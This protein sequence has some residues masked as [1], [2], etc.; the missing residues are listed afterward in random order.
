MTSERVISALEHLI[1]HIVP[2]DPH[3]HPDAAQ[4]RHDARLELVTSMIDQ[5][6]TNNHSRA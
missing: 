2:D 1:A 5:Y 4:E 3:E 6:A